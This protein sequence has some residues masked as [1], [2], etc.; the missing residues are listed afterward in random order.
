MNLLKYKIIDILI[1]IIGNGKSAKPL[2][3]DSNDWDKS[4]AINLKSATNVISTKSY[5]SDTSGTIT[6]ISSIC[7]NRMIENAL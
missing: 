5:L 7:G 4:F 2:D 3:E 6:C 1:C